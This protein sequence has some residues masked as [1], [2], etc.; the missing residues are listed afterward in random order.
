MARFVTIWFRHLKTDW[1]A[2]RQP[3]LR[4]KP[5]VLSSPDR[6]RMVITAADKLAIA[7]GVVVGMVV[8]DARVF[9][10]S[11]QVKDDEAGLAERLLKKIAAWCIR[12]TN[13]VAIDLP[14]GIIMDVTGCA[15]LWGGEILYIE[16]INL[17]LKK[18]GY[19]VRATMADTIGGA[20][21]IA[22]F[23]Y[24]SPIVETNRQMDA[25]LS[26]PPAA[27]RLEAAT[28]DRLHKLGLHQIRD[29]ISMPRAALRRRFGKE[30]LIRIDQALGH[31]EEPIH[32]VQPIEP[33]RERLPCLEP[34]VT[35]TGIE[36]ALNRLL[37]RICI[38]LQQE[39]MGIRKAIFSGFRIDGK[40][41]K[42]EIGTHRPSHNRSHLYKLFE[43]KICTI[44]PGPG[45]ELFM[46]EASKTEK[47]TPRQEKLWDNVCG[48]EDMGLSE[49]MDRLA[50]RF[51]D[52]PIHRYLPAEH[53]LPEKSFKL[54]SSLRE[55]STSNWM[56]DRPRPLQLLPIPQPI[57]VTAPIPD[58]P[59]MLF[60]Y[61]GILH[62]IKK[63]DGPER[64]EQEWWIQDGPHRDYYSVEDEEGSRYWLFRSGHYR[65]NESPQWFIHGFFA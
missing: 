1:F 3:A 62:K 20:W 22:H 32:P 18:L 19:H 50:N 37:D 23:G 43:D 34:I 11:L 42:I 15:H 29:F 7:A 16:E 65:E 8:A 52:S 51:S 57:E 56:I 41:E 58:Y 27:L 55:S 54:S 63:A 46:I 30:F 4:N 28:I 48:L 10:P 44:G 40:M 61:R 59:P 9:I 12:Y 17:R 47:T 24:D 2:I 60:R 31:E 14:D 39:G 26:L 25:L 64:I 6:G 33:W 21:A 53:Y 13:I 38:R 49:L 5:F 36:I 35:V 45:I